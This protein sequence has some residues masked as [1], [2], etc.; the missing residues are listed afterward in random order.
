M[1]K[2]IFLTAALMLSGHAFAA[3][4]M[5]EGNVANGKA[6]TLVCSA[7][8]GNDGNSAA[9]SFP[10]LAGQGEKYLYKQLRDIRDGAR[11]IATMVGLLDTKTDQELADMAAYYAD[12]SM[13]GS[14]ADPEKLALGERIYRAGYAE[15]GVAACMACHGPTGHGNALAGFPRL[16]GQ[17]ADYTKSQLIMYRKGFEDPSGRTNDG[18]TMVMRANARGLSD[19]QI[20]AVSSYIAGLK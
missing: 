14:Q 10:K 8:H 15:T 5:P 6:Q 19:M 7:C 16:A 9:P 3:V 17:H 12:Q 11:P 13:S 2:K 1:K 18:D 4:P 20:D